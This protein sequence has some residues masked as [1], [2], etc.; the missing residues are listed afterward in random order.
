MKIG[1]FGDSYAD[2]DIHNDIAKYPS[3]VKL[4]R[5]NKHFEI[6]SFGMSGTSL[7]YSYKQFLNNH[8]NFDKIIFVVTV[9]GRIMIPEYIAVPENNELLRHINNAK[10]SLEH[11]KKSTTL[12]FKNA[13]IAAKMYYEYLFDL[14]K[15][16]LYHR[17]M[18]EEIKRIRS[19]VIIVYTA[20]P[21]IGEVSLSEISKREITGANLPIKLFFSNDRRMCH[22]SKENNIRLANLAERWINGEA[23][24]LKFEDFIVPEAIEIRHLFGTK[25]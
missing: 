20:S 19:D 1:I 4:L 12:E 24:N 6:N 2:E 14:E 9:P 22:L 17:L 7:Y 8:K 21:I 13:C 15:E 5:S 18:V 11:F 3:W 10:I 16:E 23:V 25:A